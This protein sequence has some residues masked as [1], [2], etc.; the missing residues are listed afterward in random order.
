MHSLLTIKFLKEKKKSELKTKFENLIDLKLN[1]TKEVKEKETKVK[2][3]EEMKKI[4][5]DDIIKEE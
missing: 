4:N 3:N 1:S 2:V 5:K